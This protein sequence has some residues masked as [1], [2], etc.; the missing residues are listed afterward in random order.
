MFLVKESVMSLIEKT[1]PTFKLPA[2]TK[3]LL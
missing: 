3:N 1:T 2:G